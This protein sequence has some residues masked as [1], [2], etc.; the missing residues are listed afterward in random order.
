MAKIH[1]IYFDINTG[2]CPGV[3]H[4]LASLNAA[5]KKEGHSVSLHHLQTLEPE[6]E[7]A[8]KAQK[9]NADI[10]GFSFTTNQKQFVQKY[11]EAIYGRTQKIQIAGGVHP[12]IEPLDTLQIG[13]IT[14]VCVGEGESPL[15]E[16]LW[17]VDDKKDFTNLPG[18]WWRASNGDIVRNPTPPLDPDMD[19]MPSP[20]YSVFNT[21]R[22]S[23]A[24]SG[25]VAV[26]L[27]R[28]CPYNCYYCCN[29]VLR[30][31]YPNKKH[32]VRIPEPE[33]AIRII[34]DS[35]AYY[36]E[37]VGIN[38]ADDLLIYKHEWFKKF[39]ELYNKNIGLPYTCNGRIEH[40]TDNIITALKK[41]NCKTAYVGFESG[42]EWVRKNLLNRH[43]TNEEIIDCIRRIRKHGISVF[44]YNIVGFPFETKE[45]MKETL[46]L[47][48]A[49]KPTSGVVFYFYPYPATRLFDICSKFNLLTEG[50]QGLSNYLE[51]PAIKLTHCTEQDCIKQYNK[52]RLFLASNSMVSSLKLPGVFNKLFYLL[53]SI[54]PAF[55][56]KLI[57]KNSGFKNMARKLFYRYRFG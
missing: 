9:A 10:I 3:N 6:S 38:F 53:F 23:S 22:I 47:N 8:E 46:L 29:H 37:V 40:F 17:C 13:H 21:D 35:L 5:L 43:H 44:A 15:C 49:A 4:G 26:M 45:Q 51:K 20:D 48:K 14:G 56:V 11:S 57:T 55:W 18:F 2:S 1:F 54:K 50:R 27:T 19:K 31:I 42:N 12:T 33:H 25:W 16:L 52:L 24:C 41:S 39:A 30:S 28:G 34:K 36:K 32:Y 7:V